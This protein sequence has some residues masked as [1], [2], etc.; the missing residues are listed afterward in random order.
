MAEVRRT[1]ETNGPSIA[2]PPQVLVI[3]K[4]T[5]HGVLSSCPA[6]CRSYSFRSVQWAQDV[7][8]AMAPSDVVVLDTV[9]LPGAAEQMLSWWQG[10]VASVP[11]LAVLDRGACNDLVAQAVRVVD[12]FML[13]PI[14]LVEVQHRLD[15]LLGGI[16]RLDQP[17]DTSGCGLVG[18]SPSFTE[19][20]S[21]LTRVARANVPVLLTG[22]TGTG[23][24]VCA[25]ALHHLGRRR[26]FP[27]IAVDCGALPEHLF[28]NEM[29]GHA[30]G[31]YTD[32]HRDQRGLVALAAGGTLFLDEVDALSLPS[33][34]KLLR[35]LE[36]RSYRPLGSERFFAADVNVVA[37]T[38]RDLDVAVREGRFRADLYF[39]LNVLAL[40]LPPLRERPGDITLLAEHFLRTQAGGGGTRLTPAA[41]AKLARHRWPGNVRELCNV[42]RRALVEAEGPMILPNHIALGPHDEGPDVPES[43]LVARAAA[44]ADF[45]RRYVEELLRRNHGNVSAAAREARKDRRVFGRLVKKHGID[46]VAF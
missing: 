13:S 5:P 26:N 11:T 24:E 40:H 29:F 22:E 6:H 9:G 7:S 46:R 37:A 12:D 14:E 25:R 42:V 35:F 2:M 38:N 20:T 8:P 18:A 33:Q 43:F 19:V 16:T 45:E 34:S 23:K 31:A 1:A 10:N 44:V 30:R 15:R 36:E 28:E 32:A 3:G 21:R 4:H 27:F 41:L 39:R 17:A